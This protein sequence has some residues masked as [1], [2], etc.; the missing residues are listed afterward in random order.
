MHFHTH[1]CLFLLIKPIN[2]SHY[3]FLTTFRHR[4]HFNI[5]VCYSEIIKLVFLLI[6]HS[7]NSFFNNNSYIVS[8]GW[9]VAF[10]VRNCACQNM[11]VSILVLQTFAIKSSSSSC[12][13]YHKS[14]NHHISC[15][16]C[17]ISYSLKTKHRIINKERNHRHSIISVSTSRCIK[18]T[19]SSSFVDAFL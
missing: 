7:I 17:Q 18:R 15:S 10:Y 6:I 1:F 5:F 8:I 16:P 12:S 14:F 13:T 3:P 2:S 11:A 9:I 19:H 4:R